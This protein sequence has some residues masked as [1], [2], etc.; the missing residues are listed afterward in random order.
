M[1]LARYD[2]EIE[3]S[4]REARSRER[5]A[6]N[7]GINLLQKLNGGELADTESAEALLFIRRLWVFFIEDLGNSRN[8]LPQELRAQLISIGLWIIKE[9]DRIRESGESDVG[10]LVAINVTIRDALA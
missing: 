6:L 5:Q 8:G 9:A 3:D 10:D 7:H 2:D 4:A 1:T